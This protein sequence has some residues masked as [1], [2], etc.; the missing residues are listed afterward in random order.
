MHIRP[1]QQA[2]VTGGADKEVKF[3]NIEWRQSDDESV[4]LFYNSFL[5]THDLRPR[6]GKSY[7]LSTRAPSK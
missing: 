7:L 3:W 2:L 5:L 6:A 4:C 1:D